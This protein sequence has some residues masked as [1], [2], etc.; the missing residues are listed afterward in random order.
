MLLLLLLLV[1]LALRFLLLSLLLRLR[2]LLLVLLP[3]VGAVS[4]VSR[5][6]P[7]AWLRCKG[8]DL[9]WFSPYS[10]PTAPDIQPVGSEFVALG[11]YAFLY[12]GDALLL[13]GLL[14]LLFG[15]ANVNPF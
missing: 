6:L 14:G 4:A 1:L 12:V 8:M 7:R 9:A 13:S 5:V 15:G 2:G 11:L 3:L 10:A